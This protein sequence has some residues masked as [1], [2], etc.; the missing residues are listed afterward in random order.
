VE[1]LALDPGDYTGTYKLI[2][3]RVSLDFVNTISWPDTER[4]HDWVTTPANMT[5]WLRAVGLATTS[6]TP[7]DIA[8]MH[9]IRSDLDAM[10]RPLAHGKHPPRTACD[11]FNEQVAQ[12]QQRRYI[13]PVDLEWKWI[14][15]TSGR[16]LLAP[17]VLDAAGLVTEGD[18][19]R[20]RYCPSCDWIFE[21]QTRNGRRRWCDM[22]DCGSRA[23]ARAYYERTK[24]HSSS[25]SL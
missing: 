21:D 12:A 7:A 9:Q 15:A 17:V 6:I 10:V 1:P 24:A 25:Q 19:T 4:E 11:R 20:L 16:H 22:A 5:T 3:G 2:G 18:H 14:P 8:E 23:K 13:D